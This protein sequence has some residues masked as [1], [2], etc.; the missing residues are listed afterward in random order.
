VPAA[1]RYVEAAPDPR[2]AA[3]VECY[4]S[5]R[6]ED[7]PAVLN[8]VLPDGCVDLIA[9]VPGMSHALAVGTMRKAL[10]VP[11]SGRMDLF[12][13]RFHPG[14]ALLFVDIPLGQLTD[15]RVP[16]ETLWGPSSAAFTDAATAPDRRVERV[17][18]L[19][20]SRLGREWNAR[21]D[22]ALAERAVGLM[23]RARGGAGIRDVAA[24]LSV[25]ERRLQRAFERSVGLAPKVLSRVLRF[26]RAIREIDRGP[27]RPVSWAAA[28][29]N[30]GY[31]DQPHFIREFKALAGVTPARWAAERS[32][33][34]FLQY[35][36]EV[37]A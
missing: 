17:E 34:G 24:A 22:E 1:P 7:T 18:R 26:R 20:L 37:N 6:A 10:L 36:E 25:G 13:V 9:G 28:A 29:A 19:L 32:H 8:R 33:V 21:S 3:W 5:I 15:T 2:L 30:A 23:R 14:A 16:L 12:G 31:A 11:M 27:T 4:W 35:G